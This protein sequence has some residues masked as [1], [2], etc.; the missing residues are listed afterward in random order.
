MKEI[1]RDIKDYEGIYQVSNT[2]KIKSLERKVY[3][4][5]H[6]AIN[7]KEKIRKFTIHKDG[8][9]QVTLSF[10]GVNKIKTVSNLV[11]EHF[12]EVKDIRECVIHL[13]GNTQNNNVKNLKYVTRR[14]VAFI[15]E[16]KSEHKTSKKYG[17][18]FEK[19]KNRYRASI[20]VLGK[21]K[22]LGTFKTEKEAE[23]AYK[24]EY[25]LN[26]SFKETVYQIKKQ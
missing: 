24:K 8:R 25:I 5:R 6:G 3:H 11:A 4:P 7:L 12:K 14:D 19:S 20:T 21:Q 16:N 10:E 22:T 26:N 15:R 9:Y 17:V 13:D 1:W 18:W 23:E 2:G